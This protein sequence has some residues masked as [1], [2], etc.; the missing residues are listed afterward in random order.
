MTSSENIVGAAWAS[1]EKARAAPAIHCKR[2]IDGLPARADVLEPS[3]KGYY[4]VIMN[5]SMM[6][7]MRGRQR[8]IDV[9]KI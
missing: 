3:P 9:S 1:D 6:S 2:D 8:S 4:R 5:Y 7:S